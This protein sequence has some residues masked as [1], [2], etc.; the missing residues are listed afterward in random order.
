MLVAVSVVDGRKARTWRFRCDCGVE[1]E[2]TIYNVTKG[3]TKSCGCLKSSFNQV[4][5]TKHGESPRRKSGYKRSSEYVTWCHMRSRCFSPLSPDYH[6]YGQR[7]ITICER[8]SDFN[9]F[10]ED[11]GRR[12][13][14]KHSLER[15]DVNGHYEP[16]NCRW[17]DGTEQARNRRNTLMV[18]HEGVWV[19]AATLAEK[20]GV[21]QKTIRYRYRDRIKRLGEFTHPHKSA[22]LPPQ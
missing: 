22:E 5:K 8:W 4:T 9:S 17:A 7:G 13:S 10:L 14:P 11:M 18:E 12:P 20:L 15:L 6:N 3:H 19:P 1:K 21:S 16:D 2:L